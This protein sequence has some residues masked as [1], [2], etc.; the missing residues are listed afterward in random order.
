[1]FEPRCVQTVAEVSGHWQGLSCALNSQGFSCQA[2][3]AT[4]SGEVV[5]ASRV[6]R[7][8]NRRDRTALSHGRPFCHPTNSLHQQLLL[9]PFRLTFSACCARSAM[10]N[11]PP[12]LATILNP[13]VDPPPRGSRHADD[14]LDYPSPT[15]GASSSSS[16]FSLSSSASS[17]SASSSALSGSSFT[18]SSS[19]AFRRSSVAQSAAHPRASARSGSGSGSGS[20]SL[21]GNGSGR[22]GGA[23]IASAAVAME[24]A[25]DFDAFVS[26]RG[27]VGSGGGFISSNASSS[28]S[29]S[30][31]SHAADA[32]ESFGAVTSV[33]S[34]QAGVARNLS[35]VYRRMQAHTRIGRHQLLHSHRIEVCG[36]SSFDGQYCTPWTAR[37]RLCVDRF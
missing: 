9:L 13:Q 18:T 20:G 11:Q 23:P 4:G 25:S 35:G 29:S 28:S 17:A 22:F 1:M 19:S 30:S 33:G 26:N 16:S 27:R 21:S 15:H 37:W 6:Q 10:G 12:T 3:A 24:E 34:S 32:A 14:D 31:T 7:H 2:L 8:L 5:G 36:A